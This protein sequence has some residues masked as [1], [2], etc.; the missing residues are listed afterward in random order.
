LRE[1]ERE[2]ERERD[3]EKEK[4]RENHQRRNRTPVGNARGAQPR[5]SGTHSWFLFPPL[6]PHLDLSSQE[7]GVPQEWSSVE[8]DDESEDSQVWWEILSFSRCLIMK[9]SV[10]CHISF[11]CL[12]FP[13][14]TEVPRDL[15]WDIGHIPM[16]VRHRVEDLCVAYL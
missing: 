6:L 7:T 15:L 8:E 3:R 10:G 5:W 11:L 2:R 4:E 1:R 9:T 16:V 12:P 13:C 14:P